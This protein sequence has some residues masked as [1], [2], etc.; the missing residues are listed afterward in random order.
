MTVLDEAYMLFSG[1][2]IIIIIIHDIYEN[3]EIS[4][5]KNCNCVTFDFQG[6]IFR[7]FDNYR[8]NQGAFIF[9]IQKSF[10]PKR[11]TLMIAELLYS[12]I[13]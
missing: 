4:V 6:K 2:L 13:A 1:K 11:S 10:T 9:E 5:C 12:V 8:L 3:I 7:K